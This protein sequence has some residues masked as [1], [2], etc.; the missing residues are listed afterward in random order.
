MISAGPEL[1]RRIHRKLLDHLDL[2][3]L[4]QH[5]MDERIMR[6]KVKDALQR[7]I[8]DLDESVGD[9]AQAKQLIDEMCD[10]ALGL[11]PLERLLADSSVTEIMVVSPQT[12]FVERAGRPRAQR[13]ALHG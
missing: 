3:N 7:I 1:R 13:T 2:V 6:P 10:E 11:G 8:A 12:I 5:R 4:D 9:D